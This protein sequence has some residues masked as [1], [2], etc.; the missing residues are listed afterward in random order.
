MYR[1]HS[2]FRRVVN[3]VRGE[4]LI[5]VAAREVGRGPVNILAEGFD[6]AADELKV[7]EDLLRIGGTAFSRSGVEIYDSRWMPSAF[8]LQDFPVNLTVLQSFLREQ[9]PPE[10]LGFLLDPA[11]EAAPPASFQGRLQARAVVL[12]E[13]IFRS[14][15]D[16]VAGCRG[17][18]GLGAGLTPAGD[19]FVAGVLAAL[20]VL[21]RLD[22]IDRS[23]LKGKIAA[24]VRG[25]NLIVN[26]FISLTAGGWFFERL[27]NLLDGL[28]GSDPDEVRR[29]AR[30]LIS[31]GAS[32]GS[33]LAAGLLLTLENLRAEPFPAADPA[34]LAAAGAFDCSGQGGSV[35]GSD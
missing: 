17:F 22:G 35:R 16:L 21:E 29:R 28:G 6:P 30:E 9:S 2:R 24:V 3:F 4:E 19:D 8:S 11:R 13:N 15:A 33:D 10:S 20:G 12:A 27:K 34:P 25:T 23:G 7:E 14:E 1:V 5:A 31:F 18:K 32:S 26:S